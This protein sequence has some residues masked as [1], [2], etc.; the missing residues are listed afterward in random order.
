MPVAPLS[1]FFDLYHEVHEI[2]AT[3]GA[4]DGKVRA[5]DERP[6][7]FILAALQPRAS[8]FV[9]RAVATAHV[10]ASPVDLPYVEYLECQRN[11]VRWCGNLV[12]LSLFSDE[13][14]T[15]IMN[16]LFN[17]YLCPPRPAT[18]STAVVCLCAP[19]VC[20]VRGELQ[21]FL[22]WPAVWCS[23]SCIG[24]TCCARRLHKRLVHFRHRSNHPHRRRPHQS[25]L[26]KVMPH[27]SLGA[28]DPSGRAAGTAAP[29]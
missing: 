1:S 21:P 13:D 8:H 6:Q 2:A 12:Q 18:S 19:V 29:V 9:A 22:A 24:L 4:A 17:K 26:L 25:Q 27:L 10:Q 7:G 20:C 28:S 5:D 14:G 15:N 23:H 16:V 11:L 3:L